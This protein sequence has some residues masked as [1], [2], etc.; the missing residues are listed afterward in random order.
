MKKVLFLVCIMA[1]F[2]GCGY[3]NWNINNQPTTQNGQNTQTPDIVQEPVK[4]EDTMQDGQ[5]IGGTQIEIEQPQDREN[6][7]H[8]N[9]VVS[10]WGRPDNEFIDDDNIKHYI[11][12][13]CKDT[14]VYR[15]QCVGEDC[16][17]VPVRNCCDRDLITDDE[18][19]VI[20]L[21]EAVAK[22]I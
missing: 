4:P 13:N 18:G 8:I 19:Y 15:E 11:W 12:K 14:G 20:N 9:T 2:G 5:T 10:T 17:Q 1:F 21:K 16:K 6:M 3:S 22:C 7:F